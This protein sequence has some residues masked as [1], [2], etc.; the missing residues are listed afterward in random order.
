MNIY[1]NIILHNNTYTATAKEQIFLKKLTK[2][3]SF[4]KVWNA[5]AVKM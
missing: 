2:V 1:S 4:K 5:M 3:P